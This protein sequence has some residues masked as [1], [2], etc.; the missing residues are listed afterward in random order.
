MTRDGDQEQSPPVGRKAARGSAKQPRTQPVQPRP[1]GAPETS[2]AELRELTE[3][4]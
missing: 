1:H 2:A 3:L 4:V